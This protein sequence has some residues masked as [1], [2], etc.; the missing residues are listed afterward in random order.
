MWTV[1]GATRGDI[2]SALDIV[3]EYYEN[4]IQMMDLQETGENE[5]RFQLRVID[6]DKPGHM[7]ASPYE[8]MRIPTACYHVKR[9]FFLELPDE[10]AL[11]TGRHWLKRD[12]NDFTPWLVKGKWD[13]QSLCECTEKLRSYNHRR[14]KV[15]PWLKIKGLKGRR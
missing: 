8:K 6:I 14:R 2:E 1:Q 12:E 11:H 13:V 4:N 5:F 10:A 3:N 7:I 9:L 15:I